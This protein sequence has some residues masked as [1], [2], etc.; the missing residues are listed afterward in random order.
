MTA[1]P[2]NP[3]ALT[4]AG[5][6]GF[7]APLYP[8]FTKVTTS[9][10]DPGELVNFTG[11]AVLGKPAGWVP[12]TYS[13]GACDGPWVGG[14][15]DTH[16][17]GKTGLSHRYYRMPSSDHMTSPGNG[18]IYLCGSNNL[19][20]WEWLNDGDPVLTA[21]NLPDNFNQIEAV[22]SILYL[23]QIDKFAIYPHGQ[24]AGDNL[25]QKTVRFTTEDFVTFTAAGQNESS[26]SGIVIDGIGS[27][28][29]YLR[30]F[31]ND[32]TLFGISYVSGEGGTIEMM[33][34]A[35]DAGGSVWE[36]MTRFQRSPYAEPAMGEFTA[37]QHR[38]IVW[39]H[40]RLHG[41]LWGL[42]TVRK[43]DASQAHVRD[44]TIYVAPMA[45]DYWTIVG[46]PREVVTKG[47]AGAFDDHGI[48]T[49]C[50]IVTR[51]HV[52]IFYSGFRDDPWPMRMGAARCLL[53]KDGTYDSLGAA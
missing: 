16:Y 5:Q 25:I 36:P 14:I 31:W 7:S 50:C 17:Y 46:V 32:S 1:I 20:K 4:P 48:V 9:V 40:F 44:E 43:D 13:I 35:R 8:R 22:A 42:L 33:H 53:R 38:V 34:Q 26:A 2:E 49:P 27:H 11:S 47:S 21:S 41:Q 52:W 23:P 12:Y 3:T 28:H 45:N 29:G 39:G 30:N 10:G 15:I 51:T 37:Q 18:A 19:L 24:D 6:S